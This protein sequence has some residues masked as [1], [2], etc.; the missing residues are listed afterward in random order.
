MNYD[1]MTEKVQILFE[2]IIKLCKENSHSNITI[3]HFIKELLKEKES[4][5]IYTL[6]KDNQNINKITKYVDQEFSKLNKSSNPSTNLDM[7][8]INFLFF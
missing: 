2:N 1:E 5:F 7:F 3:I 6:K 4:M 8:P